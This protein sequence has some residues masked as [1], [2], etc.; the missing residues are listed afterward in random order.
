[1][2]LLT[3]PGAPDDGSVPEA[4]M[5][6]DADA[7]DGEDDES[8]DKEEEDAPDDDGQGAA[9]DPEGKREI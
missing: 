6:E 1:M 3:R 2:L 4:G 9:V 8:A 7:K 5:D